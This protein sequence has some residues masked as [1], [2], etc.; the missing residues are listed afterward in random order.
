MKIDRKVPT[1]DKQNG[2][3]RGTDGMKAIPTGIAAL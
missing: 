2:Q 1:K 3:G